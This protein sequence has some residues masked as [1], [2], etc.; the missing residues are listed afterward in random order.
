VGE[1]DKQ[2]ARCHSATAKLPGLAHMLKAFF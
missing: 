1:A 2:L